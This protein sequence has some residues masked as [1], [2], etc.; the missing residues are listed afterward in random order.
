MYKLMFCSDP[1]DVRIVRLHQATDAEQRA[2]VAWCKKGNFV[3]YQ[4]K[5]GEATMDPDSDA[6]MAAHDG[7]R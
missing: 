4:G 5:F 3:K 1:S 7:R 2:A 6:R